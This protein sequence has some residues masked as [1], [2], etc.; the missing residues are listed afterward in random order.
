VRC[1]EV[2]EYGWEGL[3]EDNGKSACDVNTRANV[4]V[5]LRVKVKVGV[6]EKVDVKGVYYRAAYLR[7]DPQ[8]RQPSL[9]LQLLGVGHPA[10]AHDGHPSPSPLPT[11][12]AS[13]SEPSSR[14][15]WVGVGYCGLCGEWVMT[16]VFER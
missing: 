3:R 12:V 8:A 14:L 15:W 2:G 5:D 10:V 4:R 16:S 6:N 1:G 13:I 7:G 11:G 9:D